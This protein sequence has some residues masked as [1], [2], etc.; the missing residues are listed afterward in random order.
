ME[1]GIEI[2]S[3]ND[4]PVLRKNAKNGA[5]KMFDLQTEKGRIKALVVK[6]VV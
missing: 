6:R 4:D 1:G 5:S 3:K 2:E